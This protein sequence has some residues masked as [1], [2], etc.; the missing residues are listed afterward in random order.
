MR[1]HPKDCGLLLAG[2]RYCGY[3]CVI[4]RK[5]TLSWVVVVVS[6]VVVVRAKKVMGGMAEW[7][8]LRCWLMSPLPNLFANEWALAAKCNKSFFY[9]PLLLSWPVSKCQDLDFLKEKYVCGS[10]LGCPGICPMSFHTP[11]LDCLSDSR[12]C[13]KLQGWGPAERFT[14]G[15][16]YRFG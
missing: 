8:I 5:A 16:V 1:K 3:W 2:P 9:L 12:H 6:W 14:W 7:P 4:V 13:L 10:D 11:T 15:L